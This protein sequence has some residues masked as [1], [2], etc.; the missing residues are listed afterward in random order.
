[1]SPDAIILDSLLKTL[2]QVRRICPDPE[3]ASAALKRE[4]S[5]KKELDK[6]TQRPAQPSPGAQTAASAA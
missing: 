5:L 2:R 1:M 6:L 4:L 3:V